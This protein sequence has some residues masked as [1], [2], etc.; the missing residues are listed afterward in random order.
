MVAVSPLRAQTE[1]TLSPTASP[2][3]G[4]PGVTVINVTGSGFP[5]GTVPPANVTVSLQPSAGGS[6]FVTTPTV[7]TKIIGT[8]ERVAFQIPSSIIVSSPTP[9][10]VSTAGS[11]STGVTFASGNTA[12]LTINPPAQMSLCRPTPGR[13]DKHSRLQ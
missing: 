3:T 12:S 2:S 10:Q 5:S 7:V 1:V 9:Y 13:G 4:Q 8:T 11:T 6:P